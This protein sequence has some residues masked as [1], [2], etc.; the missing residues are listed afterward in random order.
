MRTN[1]MKKTIATATLT[2]SLFGCV[3]LADVD[4]SKKNPNCVRQCSTTAS[5]CMGNAITYP[6]VSG[7]R[8]A[9]KIC[10]DSCPDK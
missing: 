5:Q 1:I 8:D 2:L 10:T 6:S 9:F 7:C 4:T 3:S